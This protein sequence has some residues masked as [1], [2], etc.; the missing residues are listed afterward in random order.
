MF[1][2]VRSKIKYCVVNCIQILVGVAVYENSIEKYI[3]LHQIKRVTEP[4]HVDAAPASTLLYS[5]PI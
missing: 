4:H 1:T 3:R 2:S 5:I